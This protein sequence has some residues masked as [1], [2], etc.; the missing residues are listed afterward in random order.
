MF[1]RIDV[2]SLADHIKERRMRPTVT[3]FLMFTGKAEAAMTFYVSLFGDGLVTSVTRHGA[4][5]GAQAGKIARASFTLNGQ[6]FIC[7]D[8]PPVHAFGFTPSVSLFVSCA[9][10]DEVDRLFAAL[11]D[12]GQV[13]MGLD[14]YPFSPRYGWL[15]DRFGV[16]W[17]VA[18]EPR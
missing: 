9:T 2:Q 16:S 10:A 3:P 5:T 18:L 12:G 17:Q 8:S 13:L 4:E 7:F 14:A 1:Q 11:S 15:N 6:N